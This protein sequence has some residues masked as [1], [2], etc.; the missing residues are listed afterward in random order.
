[1]FSSMLILSLL[2]CVV[3]FQN[4]HASPREGIQSLEPEAEMVLQRP[5]LEN[6]YKSES[7]LH[8]LKRALQ[9]LSYDEPTDDMEFAE[10]NV[11]R[12]LFSYR[13]SKVK[14]R[15]QQLGR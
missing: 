1:M 9:D 7:A 13:F 4:C 15:P 8:R 5:T 2:T 12:P 6:L 10:I 3:I 11:F 14:A